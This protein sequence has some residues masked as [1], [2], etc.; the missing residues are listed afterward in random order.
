VSR[1]L[2]LIITCLFVLCAITGLM[3][4]TPHGRLAAGREKGVVRARMAPD[5][6]ID[7]DDARQRLRAKGAALT[8]LPDARLVVRKGDR[9]LDLYDGETLIATYPIV[10]GDAPEGTK[11]REGDSRTPEG[12][13]YL[14]TRI[15]PSTYHIF[16]GISYPSPADATRVGLSDEQ[17]V[18]QIESAW[19]S[20]E[21]PPWNSPLG[22]AVGVHGGGVAL[23]WTAGCIAMR[24]ADIEEIAA[25]TSHGNPITIQP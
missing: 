7:L 14:C 19:E 2:R 17:T 10:L 12:D 1:R 15:S 23:D 11:S 22:G 8:P 18:E 24:N 4:F 9:Q 3:A 21:K 13:Y 25:A 5:D 16:L 20:R 6:P